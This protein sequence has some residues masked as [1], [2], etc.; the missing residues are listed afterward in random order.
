[1]F[2]TIIRFGKERQSK[3]TEELFK[4]IDSLNATLMASNRAMLDE[5][6]ELNERSKKDDNYRRA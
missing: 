6:K 2:K 3:T 4:D 5:V 1:M